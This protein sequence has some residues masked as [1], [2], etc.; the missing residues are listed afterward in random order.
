MDPLA[1]RV[2]TTTPISAPGSEKSI[3][4]ANP[5]SLA[6]ITWQC[7]LVLLFALCTT[8][9]AELLPGGSSAENSRLMPAARYAM[10]QDTHVMMAVG[11]AEDGHY[12]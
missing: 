10:W 9:A 7:A 12:L 11:C 1:I 4:S 6:L 3:F 5:F 2:P 8:F